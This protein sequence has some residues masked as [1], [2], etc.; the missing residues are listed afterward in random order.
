MT[1]R[2]DRQRCCAK[3][4]HANTNIKPISKLSKLILRHRHTHRH[5][6]AQRLSQVCTAQRRD[7]R[8]CVCACVC[9]AIVRLRVHAEMQEIGTRCCSN[10]HACAYDGIVCVRVHA[11]L[12]CAQKW[13]KNANARGP[14]TRGPP[15]RGPPTTR[16]L[17]T[18]SS[19]AGNRKCVW[20]SGLGFTQQKVR[21]LHAMLI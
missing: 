6:T 10:A 3:Q 16:K 17:P 8:K 18:P 12:E 19:G 15:T 21:L 1:K 7:C 5:S 20:V 13:F 4:N 14:P 2:Q 9:D 11:F